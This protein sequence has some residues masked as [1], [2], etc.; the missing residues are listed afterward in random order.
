MRWLEH[1]VNDLTAV[2]E[3]METNRELKEKNVCSLER[4]PKAQTLSTKD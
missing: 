3:G 2:S 1:A 4:K